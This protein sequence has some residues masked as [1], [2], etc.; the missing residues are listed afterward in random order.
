MRCHAIHS[1]AVVLEILICPD[2]RKFVY[3]SVLFI[4]SDGG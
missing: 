3:R 2:N 1:I 4:E